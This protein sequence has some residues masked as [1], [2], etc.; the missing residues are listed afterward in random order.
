MLLAEQMAICGGNGGRLGTN[1]LSSHYIITITSAVICIISQNPFPAT[2]HGVFTTTFSN[3][4]PLLIL[5]PGLDR[6]ANEIT[7]I[8]LYDGKTIRWYVN[9]QNLEQFAQD[10]QDYALLVTYNGK[11]FDVPFIESYL[12]VRLDL[13]HID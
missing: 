2:S 7:T 12:G 10:I 11:S 9:G 6:V 13:G 3:P 5:R 4:V 8:A 1:I